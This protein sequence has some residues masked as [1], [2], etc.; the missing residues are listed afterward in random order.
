MSGW[1][2]LSPERDGVAVTALIIRI[3]ERRGIARDTAV[4]QNSEIDWFVVTTDSNNVRLS[5]NSPHRPAWQAVIPW[6]SIIR[7]CFAAEKPRMSD[8]LYLFTSLRPESWVVPVDAVG[9][10]LLLGELVGRRLFDPSLATK[11][12]T[13]VSGLF[14]WPD[15]RPGGGP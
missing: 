11:A 9:G 7:V 8:G 5:V 13:A 3:V 1:L 4:M 14:C 2:L 6:E 12:L 15:E 10:T